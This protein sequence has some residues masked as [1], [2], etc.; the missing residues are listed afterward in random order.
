MHVVLCKSLSIT[1]KWLHA[2]TATPKRPRRNG[3]AETSDSER[4]R[5][6]HL[7]SRSSRLIEFLI[8]NSGLFQ[9]V[10]HSHHGIYRDRHRVCHAIRTQCGHHRD[11]RRH[12]QNDN[13]SKRM[14]RTGAFDEHIEPGTLTLIGSKLRY[15][16]AFQVPANRPGDVNKFKYNYVAK[17]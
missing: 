6:S 3:H 1:P 10:H 5:S 11:G 13:R 8:F 9:E 15:S 12:T 16:I 17:T 7:G 4:Y 14:S 2:K